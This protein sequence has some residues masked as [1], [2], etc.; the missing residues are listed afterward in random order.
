MTHED[1]PLPKTINSFTAPVRRQDVGI[2]IEDDAAWRRKRKNLPT[3]GRRRNTGVNKFVVAAT[4][5]GLM[6]LGGTWVANSPLNNGESHPGVT[7][8]IENSKD[9]EKDSRA[10]HFNTGDI[11]IAIN[12]ANIR[13]SPYIEELDE[14]KPA[15]I[16]NLSDLDSINGIPTKDIK[17]TDSLVVRNAKVDEQGGTV[18]DVISSTRWIELDI[19][20]DGEA[21][22]GYISDGY[23]TRNANIVS[24]L[25]P[26]PIERIV[27]D[28][29][30]NII[31]PSDGLN[32]TEIISSSQTTLK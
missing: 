16:K 17:K 6:A 2:P 3:V 11:Q 24:T 20:E 21:K 28:G 27:R 9:N 4:G 10:T 23:N 14:G 8:N 31:L 22:K 7:H 12:K 29:S 13:T 30:G 1:T 18:P 25:K 15:N 5:I 32:Y 19:V 26:G